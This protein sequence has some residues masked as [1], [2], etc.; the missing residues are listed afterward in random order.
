[1]SPP[2]YDDFGELYRAHGARLVVQLYAYTQDLSLAEDLVHEAF[3]RALDRWSLVSR[4]EDPVGW[5]R[6]LAALAVPLRRAATGPYES[7][8]ATSESLSFRWDGFAFGPAGSPVIIPVPDP[9]NL[10]LTITP[11]TVSGPSTVLTVTVHNAGPASVDYL[12]LGFSAMLVEGDAGRLTSIPIR[13]EGFPAGLRPFGS[14]EV[15]ADCSWSVR[16]EPVPAGQSAT[17]RFTVS[18]P[19]TITGGN[20]FVY[21]TGVAQG[22]GFLDNATNAN[23]AG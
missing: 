2:P 1:V 9:T 6:A 16:L 14:C 19:S 20:M 11:E 3:C 18:V 22:I 12:E 17:G 8:Q 4:Y 13:P 23:G 21:V 10:T 15:T 7:D 5:V